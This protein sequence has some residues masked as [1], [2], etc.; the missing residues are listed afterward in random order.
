M[1]AYSCKVTGEAYTILPPSQNQG[2]GDEKNRSSVSFDD[3]STAAWQ[4]GC[5][6]E[7]TEASRS[8]LSGQKRQDSIPERYRR[9]LPDL[10]HEPQWHQDRQ[11]HYQPGR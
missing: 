6:P 9:Q 1:L 11:P 3:S 5:A 8:D 2:G 4:W 10:H 7:C